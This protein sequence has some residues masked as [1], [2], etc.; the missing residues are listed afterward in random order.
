MSL[1]LL[2]R[3]LILEHQQSPRH[4][5]RIAEADAE[6][7]AFNPMCGDRVHISLKIEPQEKKIVGQ[8]FEGEGCSICMASASMMTEEIEG[9]NLDEVESRVE[10]FRSLMKGERPSGE[11]GEDIL[12]LQGVAQ[13]PVRIK[14]ALLA[15]T[16]LKDAIDEWRESKKSRE[17]GES[18][19]DSKG[20]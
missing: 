13:F 5:G 9:L 18:T 4:F 3:D 19:A 20:A 17:T 16:C 6:A 15:W 11:L 8:A 1:E 14:C 7:E 10:S 12:A 2:Y